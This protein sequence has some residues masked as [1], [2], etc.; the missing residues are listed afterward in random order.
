VPT[1]L[2]RRPIGEPE[3]VQIAALADPALRNLWI[4]TAYHD[5]AV[6]MARIVGATNVS[7]PAFAT[8]ASKTAGASIRG[9]EISGRIRDRL[10]QSDVFR[11]TV[12]RVKARLSDTLVDIDL[13]IVDAVKDAVAAV[14]RQIAS[15]NLSVFE[16]LGPLFARMVSRFDGHALGDAAGR[17]ALVDSVQ[18]IDG[19]GEATSRLKVVFEQYCQAMLEPDPALRADQILLANGLAGLTEQIRLQPNIQGALDAPIEASLGEWLDRTLEKIPARAR[20]AARPLLRI[21]TEEIERV[22]RRIATELLMRLVTP[23]GGLDLGDDVPARVGQPLFPNDLEQ[24]KE[25]ALN[26]FFRVFDLTGGTGVGSGARDWAEL[27]QRMNY[28]VNL[29]R[30]RQQEGEF[31]L[32]PFTDLQWAEMQEGRVPA[33]GGL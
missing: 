9:D 17:A 13:D 12:G 14:S 26:A 29:F 6:G 22:W 32:A 20:L 30:S 24:I 2:V 3:V 18:A 19:D 11:Q 16:E 23:S 31:L 1:V 25:A 33:G 10:G 8:W 28:I 21:V 27:P 7:W 5:L 15:G 4:T